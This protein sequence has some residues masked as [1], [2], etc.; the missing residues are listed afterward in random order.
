MIRD[1]RGYIGVSM[2]PM[3]RATLS[4]TSVNRRVNVH[5]G[6]LDD[7]DRDTSL[8][9]RHIRDVRQMKWV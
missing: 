3:N 6:Y 7:C 1:K 2:L 8:S 9:L 5:K 4:G